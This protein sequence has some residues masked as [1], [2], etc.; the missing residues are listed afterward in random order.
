MPNYKKK[1]KT[2][3]FYYYFDFVVHEVQFVRMCMQN[4]YLNKFI[5]KGTI[6][7]SSEA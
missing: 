5:I 6:L 3:T 4:N 1:K 7:K 2:E